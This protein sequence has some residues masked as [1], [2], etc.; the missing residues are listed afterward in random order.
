MIP[1]SNWQQNRA[2]FLRKKALFD[3][4]IALLRQQKEREDN[5]GRR[6]Y[7]DNL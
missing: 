3:R 1:M 2:E 7:Q 4:Q 6:Y 5:E